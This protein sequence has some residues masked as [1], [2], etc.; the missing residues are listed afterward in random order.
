MQYFVTIVR[1]MYFGKEMFGMIIES[2]E[3]A[4]SQKA[5]FE[6]AWRGAEEF[7]ISQK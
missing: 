1:D 4:K 3:I 6:L 2:E 7:N 5:I